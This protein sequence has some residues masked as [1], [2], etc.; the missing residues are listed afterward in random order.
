MRQFITF[1]FQQFENCIIY[2]VVKTYLYCCLIRA[3]VYVRYVLVVQHTSQC[4]LGLEQILL[5][6]PLVMKNA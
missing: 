6:S 2:P 3:T 4:T 1:W 5:S